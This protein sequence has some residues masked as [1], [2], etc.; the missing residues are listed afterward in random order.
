MGQASD[1]S[2]MRGHWAHSA[3]NEGMANHSSR[4]LYSAVTLRQS[5]I[6]L[7]GR[8]RVCLGS[9][10]K[11]QVFGRRRRLPTDSHELSIT[12]ESVQEFGL[13]MS[14][15]KLQLM[16]DTVAGKFELGPY[17]PKDASR[18][19]WETRKHDRF[20]EKLG[21]RIESVVHTLNLEQV[22][23]AIMG[24]GGVLRFESSLPKLIFGNN[25]ESLVTPQ[26]A[27][28]L[29][30]ECISD[31]VEGEISYLG[32]AEYL[33]VDYCHNFSF[34]N[35][36]P[37]YM[38]TLGGVSFLKH[39]RITDDH[40]GVEWWNNGRSRMVRAYDKHKEILE[41]EK[42]DISEAHGILRF[43]VQLRKKSQYLQR[44]AGNKKPT[45]NEVLQPQL[46]YA[47]LTETLNKMCLD[48]R[49]V[50]QD[51][52][53]SLLDEAFPFRKATRLLGI[54]RRLESEGMNGLRTTSARS[55]YYA[56]KRDLRILGLWPP[57]ATH[58]ELPGLVLPPLDE[59][60]ALTGGK[61]SCAVQ[62]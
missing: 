38:A 35:A 26:E 52:A 39:H 3:G 32:E 54:L 17:I 45:L 49:F 40:G 50:P 20:D 5:V 58:R 9:G 14:M 37:D 30:H 10:A 11:P 59:L 16:F 47:S 19:C 62:Q 6:A 60:T 53:R 29:L 1:F 27:L 7:A 13:S 43:E 15:R 41:V 34:G 51:M 12:W 42:K 57:S 46:A 18:N 25:F 21:A 56:D 23:I 28:N 33:R 44:R 61:Q 31:H 22:R 48:L 55:T 36:L 4:D 8:Q 2:T 24:D